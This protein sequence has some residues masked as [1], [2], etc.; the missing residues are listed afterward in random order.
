MKLKNLLA[1]S[2]LL[3]HLNLPTCLAA[4]LT[5]AEKSEKENALKSDVV[6]R[7]MNDELARSMK[8]LKLPAHQLP[9]FGSYT[10]T[11]QDFLQ[12]SAN[13]GAVELNDRSFDRYVDTNLRV[14]DKK[15]DNS[16]ISGGVLSG[17]SWGAGSDLVIDDDYDALRHGLWMQTDAMYKAAVESL[18]SAKARLQYV[19]VEDRPDCFSDA[20]PL[21]SVK[22][23]IKVELDRDA[24]QE[25]IRKLSAIFKQYPDVQNSNVFMNV[26][27]ITRRFLNSEGTLTKDS[28]TGVLIGLSAAVQCKD[29][30]DLNDYEF[31]AGDSMDDLPSQETMEAATHELCKRVTSMLDARKAEEYQGPVLFEK[32]SAAE[33]ATAI[34]P[35]LVCARPEYGG[36]VGGGSEEDQVLGKPVL[37]AAV[38]IVDDPT[39]KTWHDIKLKGGWNIDYE[40]VR[41]SELKLVDKGILKTVCST[42][43]PTRVIKVSNGHNRGGAASPGHLLLSTSQKTT[44]ADL[45]ARAIEMAKRDNLSSVLIVRRSIPAFLSYYSS[46]GALTRGRSRSVGSP[47]LVYRLDV[48]SGKEELIRGARFKELPKKGMQDLELAS[49]DTQPYTVEMP[50]DRSS[51]TLSLITPSILVKDIEVAKPGRTT[52]ALPYLKNPYFEE[53]GK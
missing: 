18:E 23:G 21:V 42:R 30:M 51:T 45:R 33:L 16:A 24:W 46:I 11:D 19:N 47:V 34:L 20:P 41:A 10:I 1:L 4:G 17:H 15:L 7:A 29:G 32:Q 2:L 38:S 31:F 6:L 53:Q 14:G 40:G 26:R 35:R 50:G 25:R 37:A 52:D 39:L 48:N 28:E 27:Q 13:F 44:L 49:D 22:E 8:G 36:P 5:E 12:I 3:C 9:Y 43:T